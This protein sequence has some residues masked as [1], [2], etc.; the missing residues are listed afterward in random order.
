MLGPSAG[1]AGVIV[2]E[3][4][5]A[6]RSTWSVIKGRIASALCLLPAIYCTGVVIFALSHAADYATAFPQLLRYII[7]PGLIALA[8]TVV[9]FKASRMTRVNVGG[10]ACGLLLAFFLTEAILEARYIASI[11]AMLTASTL[12][13]PSSLEGNQALPPG[14]TVKRLNREIGTTELRNAVLSNPPHT[15]V[16]LCL[17]NGYPVSYK[18][19]RF[20]FRN[21]DSA[22]S[23]RPELM[24]VGDSFVE[25]ICLPDGVDLAGQ[26]RRRT[27]SLLSLG[28]RGAGPLLELAMLGRY[29]PAIR[30]RLTV[31]A[32]YEG[33][34]WENLATELRLP[35]LRQALATD[36]DFGPTILP[37]ES[38]R[39]SQEQIERWNRQGPPDFSEVL[40][41]TNVRRNFLAL[42][43]TWTQLGL[44]YPTA[45]RRIPE[46]DRILQRYREIAGQWGGRVVVAYI[47]QNT[48]YIGLFPRDFVYDELR[49]MVRE[50][51]AK[52]G[53]SFIDLTP[54]YSARKNPLD[55]YGENHLTPEG[56]ALSAEVLVG[57][58]R[59]LEQGAQ[60]S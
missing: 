3:A 38:A 25:G 45:A 1:L 29:G 10:V 35:W 11:R 26:V 54:A 33:N 49:T 41:R 48:R 13:H 39:R 24:L 58:V 59:K 40:A 4:A 6:A 50:S 47:P 42:H 8:L 37:A 15:T 17:R 28:T 30:P 34:D 53:I 55:V 20:G 19:G 2:P 36:A 32:F 12:E 51:A 56:A 16:N 43:Q 27:N 52:Q 18:T 57:E 46:Y 60:G 31:I 5:I 23:S 44:G 7:V 14:W 22:F 9:A 21:P